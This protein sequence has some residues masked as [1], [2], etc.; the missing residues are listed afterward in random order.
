MTVLA[1]KFLRKNNLFSTVWLYYVVTLLP[2]IG[3][4]QVGT[5]GAADR[6]TY[7]PSL[8]PFFLAG[9]VAALGYKKNRSIIIISLTLIFGIFSWKTIEQV[10]V[11][12]NS[13]TLWTHQTDIFPGKTMDDQYKGNNAVNLRNQ[14]SR[15]DTG[16]V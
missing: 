9:L 16:L 8:G 13:L 3:L 2:V 6:Y 11:W 14:R 4:V 10:N 1:F 15:I 7:L 12:N 5:Q